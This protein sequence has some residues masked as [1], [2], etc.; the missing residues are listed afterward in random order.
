[1]RTTQVTDTC[2]AALARG[3]GGRLAT[4]DEDLEVSRADVAEL[5]GS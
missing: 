5:L 4:S 3:R 2:L 1:V